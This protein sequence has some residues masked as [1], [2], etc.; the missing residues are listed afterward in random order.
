MTPAHIYELFAPFR[1]VTVRRMFGGAGIYVDGV[2][3]ALVSDGVVYLKTDARTVAAFSQAGST[4][5]TYLGRSGQPVEMS[6][7]RMP[8]RLYDDPDELAQ[9]ADLAF[10]AALRAASSRRP[11]RRR[12]NNGRQ[13][14]AAPSRRRATD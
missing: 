10:G 3:F 5:F 8:D 12:A 13:R 6:F 11:S 14:P 4:P 1:P 9:W 7:W 2:M